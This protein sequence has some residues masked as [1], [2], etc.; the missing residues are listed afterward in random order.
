M[1]ASVSSAAFCRTC[2]SPLSGAS[3]D[4]SH[5]DCTGC[6]A[7]I[8]AAAPSP[9]ALVAARIEEL[10]RP[11]FRA[12]LVGTSY[13]VVASMVLNTFMLT[14]GFRDTN[15][16]IGFAAIMTR[17]ASRPYVFRVLVPTVID[18][19]ARI[20]P[21]KL[22]EKVIAAGAFARDPDRPARVIPDRF[23]WVTGDLWQHYIAYALLFVSLLALLATWRAILRQV[24]GFSRA[25]EDFAPAAA[26]ALL[27]TTFACGGY[28]YDFPELV[29]AGLCFLA[30]LRRA[31]PMYY[32]ALVLS[33][34]NKETGIL[35]GV[36]FVAMHAAQMT[37]ARAA[38]HLA[39][40]AAL[41]IPILVFTR[42]RFAG[43]PG[44]G[45]ED[46]LAFNL[47][48]LLSP[49]PYLSFHDIGAP[50]V[51]MPRPLNVVVLFVVGFAL[52]YRWRE[53]DARVRRV[54]VA[55]LVPLVPLFVAFGYR[56]EVRAF[57]L[58]FAP[59]FVLVCDT[60]RRVYAGAGAAPPA[61]SPAGQ[62]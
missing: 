27:P 29:L 38:G 2:S 33:C 49:E 36:M 51:P 53:K 31:W 4:L 52:F 25:F 22:A 24:G 48:Y 14:W 40:H 56:D 59:I 50:L 17:T 62:A 28:I 42:L 55:M 12:A 19:L 41:T 54:A 9:L 45:T 39:L 43:N 46:H 13:V 44:A 34:L 21:A 23:N 6:R 15:P 1:T 57:Y 18:V 3:I 26:L 47:R 20:T 11:L 58:D 5:A 7:S 16:A 60:L 10:A 32:T 37:R 30:L 61:A 8:P 35:I